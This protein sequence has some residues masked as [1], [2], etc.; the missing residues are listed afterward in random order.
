[1]S[2]EGILF[3]DGASKGNPG[4]SGAGFWI[5]QEGQIYFENSLYLG[6]QTNNQAEYR[7]LIEGLNHAKEDRFTCLSVCMDSELIVKQMKG[8]YRVRDEKLKP[9]YKQAKDLSSFFDK[10]TFTHI[11]RHLNKEADRLANEALTNVSY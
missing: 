5:Q 11:K 7:A 1:M 6:V 10:I 9:L 3:T 2:K 4:P 8:Q